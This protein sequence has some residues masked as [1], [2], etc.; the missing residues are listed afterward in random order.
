MFKKTISEMN[1][2]YVTKNYQSF[3]SLPRKIEIETI[4]RCNGKCSFCPVNVN[5]PQRPYAKMTKE[6]FFK[7]IDELKDMGYKGKISLFSNNEPFLDERIIEFHKYAKKKLKKAWFVLY[8]N[9]S[10]LTLDKLKQIVQYCDKIVIDNYS[11]TGEVNDGLYEVKRFIESNIGLRKKVYFDMRKQ[12]EI[13]T[14]RG[15]TAPNKREGDRID[16]KCVLPF[17]QL[18]IRPTGEVSLCC[19]DA[20]GKMTL[21]NCKEQTIK[22]IWFGQP[23]REVRTIMFEKGRLGIPLCSK[24]DT[25]G[26][27]FSFTEKYGLSSRWIQ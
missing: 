18:V 3:D 23:Y 19:N 27:D 26:G 24:C 6:L 15:G 25:L 13:L 20:L 9:G 22:E 2:I 12:N 7:I 11:D 17:Q 5:E 8:T 21:G 1:N 4:N 14:S 10:L 16:C